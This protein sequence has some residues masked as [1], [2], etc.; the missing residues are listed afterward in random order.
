MSSYRKAEIQN[1]VSKLTQIKGTCY[2]LTHIDQ[3]YLTMLILLFLSIIQL[4][5][6]K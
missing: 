6:V 2:F 3:T 1:D 5:F 4:I